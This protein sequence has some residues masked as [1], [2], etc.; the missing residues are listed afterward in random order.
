MIE[1]KTMKIK[2][3]HTLVLL[4]MIMIVALLAT[5]LLPQGSYKMTVNEHDRNVV[6]PGSYEALDE[7]TL[8]PP[9]ELSLP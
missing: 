3:P 1:A 8:L 2:I 7:R 4:F 9:W 5:Y 6:I